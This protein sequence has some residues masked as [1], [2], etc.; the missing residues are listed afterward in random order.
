MFLVT[1]STFMIIHFS[2][3]VNN[4]RDGAGENADCALQN[5]LFP[6]FT[7][8]GNTCSGVEENQNSVPTGC[9]CQPNQETACSY[10]PDLKNQ[11]GNQCYVCTTADIVAG[12]CSSCV[13]CLAYCNSCI[14]SVSTVEAA[15]TCL[16]SMTNPCRA[17]CVASCRK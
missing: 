10:D 13:T 8:S 16:D 11:N 14:N 5:N 12:N 3:D 9:G 4:C 1:H 17:N 7:G 15:K 2:N 6:S